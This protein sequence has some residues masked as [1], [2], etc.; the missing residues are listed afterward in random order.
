MNQIL[1]VPFCLLVFFGCAKQKTTEEPVADADGWI[2]LLTED[3]SQ[4]SEIGEIEA[5]VQNGVLSLSAVENHQSALLVSNTGFDNFR[6]E[7]DFM[8]DQPGTGVV[9][10]FNDKVKTFTQNAEYV[11]S[12][13]FNSDQQNPA[14]T[15]IATARATV[16]EDIDP[17][18]WN[19]M[20]IEANGTRLT[21][22]L[23]DQLVAVANDD[24]FSTGKIALQVPDTSGKTAKF[25]NMRVR[26]LITLPVVT[27]LVEDRF[28]SDSSRA[29]QS[30]FDG[31][32]LDGWKPLGDGSWKVE[33]GS[34][35]GYSGVEGGFLV[36]DN[37]YKNFYL[38]TKFRI[39][40]EDNSG[41]FIRKSPDSTAVTIT[42]A[43]ECNI[44]DHN[45]PAHAYS[46]GSIATHARAWY[47]MID[48][49]DWNEMEIF[50]EDDHIVMFV[51]GT[52]SSESY[53]PPKFAKAGNICLQGGIK[54]FAPDKGPSDIFFKEVMIKSFD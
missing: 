27:E 46:T 38:K 47:G 52:K 53:L 14:G 23:N 31:K 1:I 29:W 6:L 30:M 19:T 39:L 44:Y 10:R 35:H 12:T 15:V 41:I 50:A 5:A 26:Q 36:S 54:V 33:D 45:G 32:S 42:D 21:T 18:Q 2:S 20:A 48:Y 43:I 22:Y 37:A 40:K 49:S 4:W 7:F 3:L 8:V 16:L 51:N 34:I 9:F 25:R 24:R 11:V 28:R 13:D 17:E